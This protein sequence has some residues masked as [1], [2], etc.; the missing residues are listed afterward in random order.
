MPPAAMEAFAGVTAIDVRVG[1]LALRTV[2]LAVAVCVSVPL[3][4]A[5]VKVKGPV[6]VVATVWTVS[7]EVPAPVTDGGLNVPVAPVG[8]PFTV[9]ATAP[10]NPFTAATVCV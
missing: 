10:V 5:M 3:V 2:R 6:G 1:P 8:K 9:R 4:P 7:V